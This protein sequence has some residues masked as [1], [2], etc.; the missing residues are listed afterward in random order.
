[1]DRTTFYRET[2]I[3]Y[4]EDARLAFAQV[5]KN[6]AEVLERMQNEAEDTTH[7][8]ELDTYLAQELNK[9]IEIAARGAGNDLRLHAMSNCQANL[10]L[11]GHQALKFPS[12][13][14]DHFTD[15]TTEQ[16]VGTR[17]A[18][19]TPNDTP[20]PARKVPKAK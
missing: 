18:R 14:Q 11:N 13:N 17:S 8:T 20:A 6:L 9:A 15:G 2:A 7:P 10:M 4:V 1:M 3:G 19:Q 5:T 12:L 16:A